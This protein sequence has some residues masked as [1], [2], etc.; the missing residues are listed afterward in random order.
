MIYSQP[1]AFLIKSLVHINQMSNLCP[2]F[3][4]IILKIFTAKILNIRPAPV[5]VFCDHQ[6]PTIIFSP[7][8]NSIGPACYI[9]CLERRGRGARTEL[10]LEYVLCKGTFSTTVTTLGLPPP[11]L[12]KFM[13]QF[14]LV[15]R[16]GEVLK[17]FI[18]L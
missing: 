6:H 12:Q 3:F 9:Q 17:V 16:S 1:V 18:A 10:N 2:H 4:I 8:H 5:S 11:Y 15:T 7:P 14:N 13:C